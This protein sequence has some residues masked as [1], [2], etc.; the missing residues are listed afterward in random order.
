[1]W[2]GK[3]FPI[4]TS[5]RA[6][7]L[8]A[9]TSSIVEI[10]ACMAI[11]LKEW[12]TSFLFSKWLSHFIACVQSKCGNMSRANQHLLI[13]DGHNSQVTVE[14]V[15]QACHVGLDLIKFSSHTSH[16]LQPLD[17]ACF[18]PFKS[19][20]EACRDIWSLANKGKGA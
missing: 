3:T 10:G 9:I 17:V 11:Q 18:K 13:M 7:N 14:V 8:D 4:S 6:S 2:H 16:V 20:F 12:M 5:S 19:A 15:L 1:M